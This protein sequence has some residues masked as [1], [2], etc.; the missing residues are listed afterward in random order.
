MAMHVLACGMSR[1]GTTLLTT[2]LDSHPDISM[3][4]ELLPV[5]LPPVAETIKLLDAA[6]EKS[7]GDSN[8]CGDL[9]RAKD[10]K[11]LGTFVKRCAR[12]LT[13]AQEL[14]DICRA[15]ESEGCDSFDGL[16]MRT[17]LSLA[18]V[19]NK[20]R[21]EGTTSCGF[22]INSPSVS[23][24][25]PVIPDGRFIYI[26]R[27]PR[28]VVASH[29]ANDFDRTLEHICKAWVNYV[30]KFDA[31]AQANPDCAYLVRY[32]DLVA[33][34]EKTLKAALGRLGVPFASQILRFFDS[35]ASVHRG[36]HVNSDNLR[37]DFYSTSIARWQR[38]LSIDQ[39]Q[40]IQLNC[41]ALME[42]HGYVAAPTAKPV[43][44]PPELREQMAAKLA[45]KKKFGRALYAEM[46]VPFLSDH[47][48]LTWHEAA[49]GEKAR[50]RNILILRHDVDHDIDTAL[51]IARWEQQREL[52]ATYCILHTAWYYGEAKEH[53]FERYQYV[54]DA[55]Q[56]IQ[57]L[58]HEI[59]LHNNVAA[60][61]LRTGQDPIEM[62]Q[63]EIMFL[64]IHGINIT[65]T[66]SHGDRICRELD[67]WNFELFSECVYEERGGPRTVRHE[68]HSVELGMVS[69]RDLGL[70]YEAYDIPRDVYVTDS[71]GRPRTAL[72]TRGRAG[73]RRSE[74][75]NEP[76]YPMIVAILT[77]PIW[78]DF[79]RDTI[80]P[81]S[82]T[83]AVQ[84]SG[85]LPSDAST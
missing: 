56:E 5:D 31:F 25:D 60:I 20:M 21:K 35:K 16:E 12:T 10:L 82:D 27:D 36:G 66:S 83:N 61:A 72:G 73:K 78:W 68:G 24:F 53:G 37:K 71:G 81:A 18:V 17:R 50:G 29:F 47:V 48:N 32:E 74:M 57:S 55:C 67:F 14:R 9:L 23:A 46:L 30:G 41:G 49:A 3:G 63:Q 19:Q 59:N 54:V 51:K 43:K 22:K 80:P 70:A 64:R 33:R 8:A 13:T 65:G 69:M 42:R 15:F 2:I 76:P 85:T 79:Q 11:P 38:D 4:Y 62:L 1:S 77:H 7:E 45:G 40:E 58:G 34:P 39:I 52:R 28:D 75:E 6:I 84:C 44:M 26:L